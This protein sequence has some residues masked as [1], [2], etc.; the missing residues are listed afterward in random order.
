[1]NRIITLLFTLIV[2]SCTI[3][4]KTNNYGIISTN[5]VK[6]GDILVNTNRDINEETCLY[7]ILGIIPVGNYSVSNLTETIE[8]IVKKENI[9]SL[10]NVEI[11]NRMNFYF[12]LSVNICN[13][14]KAKALVLSKK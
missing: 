10:G 14:V 7:M 12:P 6:P 8:E 3:M 13:E 5:D 9:H 4:S 2:S 11:T 1:M